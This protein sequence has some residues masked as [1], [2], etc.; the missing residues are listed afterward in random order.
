MH[1][2]CVAGL[3]VDGVDVVGGGG[4]AGT[5]VDGPAVGAVYGPAAVVVGFM[6]LLVFPRENHKRRRRITCVRE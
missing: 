1:I 4:S 3:A 2:T 6:F 5:C